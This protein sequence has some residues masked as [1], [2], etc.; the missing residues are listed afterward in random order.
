MTLDEWI[1]SGDTGLSSKTM[2]A[3]LKFIDVDPLNNRFSYPSDGGDFG[4][5]YR[6]VK[7]CN[8]PK[9]GLDRV[10]EVFK[11]F[12]P[13]IDNWEEL[14]SLYEK[15]GDIYKRLKELQPEISALKNENI[16]SLDNGI[17]IK[18]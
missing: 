3:A 1:I 15:K 13:I 9:E 18:L 8:I 5:C 14:C 6:L 11:W 12:A 16:V 4:R 17:S 10:K 2:W 7:E